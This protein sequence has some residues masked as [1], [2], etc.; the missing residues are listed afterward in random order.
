MQKLSFDG[1]IVV[2]TPQEL[3]LLDVRKSMRM[4]IQMGVPLLGVVENMSFFSEPGSKKKHT[5]FFHG[6]IY[7][8]NNIAVE[9]IK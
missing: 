6:C 1:A 2:T 4:C 9:V 8:N 3:S 7:T 5:L